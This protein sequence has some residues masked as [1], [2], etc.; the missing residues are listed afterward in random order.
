MPT[1]RFGD[2]VVTVESRNSGPLPSLGSVNSDR[3]SR[4]AVGGRY[5]LVRALADHVEYVSP[6]AVRLTGDSEGL[7][8][9][10]L[11]TVH[12]RS[13]PAC[14]TTHQQPRAAPR[15][16]HRRSPKQS[17]HRFSPSLLFSLRHLGRLVG[18]RLGCEALLRRPFAIR[19]LGVFLLGDHGPSLPRL[20]RPLTRCWRGWRPGP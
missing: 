3:R 9:V 5:A 12:R 7:F 2:S 17:R 19:V 1:R 4:R 16:S 10:K 14:R 20:A 8:P 18:T 11:R 15:G 13:R 6:L